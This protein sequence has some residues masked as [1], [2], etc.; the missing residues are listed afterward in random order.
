MGRACS[1]QGGDSNPN[2]HVRA[3][4]PAHSSYLTIF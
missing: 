3:A 2:A 1:M 4:W